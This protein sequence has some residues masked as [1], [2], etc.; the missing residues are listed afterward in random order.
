MDYIRSGFLDTSALI[1]S[2]RKNEEGHNNIIECL[3]ICKKENIHRWTSS[4][5]IGEAIKRVQEILISMDECYEQDKIYRPELENSV[6]NFVEDIIDNGIAITELQLKDKE[7]TPKEILYEI[8][9]QMEMED[10]KKLSNKSPN[11][12]LILSTILYQFICFEGPSKPFLI[13]GDDDFCKAINKQG[14][15]TYNPTKKSFEDFMRKS[16][17][18]NEG[19]WIV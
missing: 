8:A 15:E 13:S 5:V 12:I 14:F 19:V 6:M 11:D 1:K 9:N 4:L 18:F 17:I 7:Y 2:W 3:K 10:F 16:K